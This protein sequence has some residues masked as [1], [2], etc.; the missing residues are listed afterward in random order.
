[1]L[2]FAAAAQLLFFP[3]GDF[4]LESGQILEKAQIGYRTWG[5]LNP[6]KDN[7]IL[8]PSWFNGKSGDLEAYIGPGNLL[9][10]AGYFVV[11]VDSFSNGVSTSPSNSE[12]QRGDKFPKITMGDMVES[13]H[14][15]MLHLGVRRLHAV[16]GISMGAMQAFQWVVQYPDFMTKAVPI[17]G[18]PRMGVKDV[19]LWTTYVKMVPGM[20]GQKRTLAELFSFGRRSPPQSREAAQ[21][22][23]LLNGL[24][25]AAGVGAGPGAPGAPQN[26]A[27]PKSPNDVRR[28]FEAVLA[29]NI[30]RRYRSLDETVK[31]IRAKLFIVT[32]QQDKVVSPELP[33][34]FADLAQARKLVLEG[35]CGHNAYKCEKDKL[36]PALN[37]FLREP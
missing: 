5:E 35:D 8:V 37:R 28:Q 13:Q 17:V 1:M 10:P 25:P 21:F 22:T 20:G 18:T 3:L 2:A 7:V 31:A 12:T 9:D 19:L 11:A 30:T 14:R 36:A 32:A 29:H 24:D 15:L 34:Q 4:K 23:E 33:N 16:V 26:I 6:A 27:I